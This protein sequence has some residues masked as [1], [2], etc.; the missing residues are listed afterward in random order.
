MSKKN[1]GQFATGHT[2]NTKPRCEHKIHLSTRISPEL[3][4]AVMAVAGGGSM[5]ATVE[6]LL[7]YGL[8]IIGA[9]PDDD[10]Q[11]ALYAK[12]LRQMANEPSEIYEN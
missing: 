11:S 7:R 1:A 8:G 6:K 3:H 9:M 2:I 10:D 12:A 5:T 4:A